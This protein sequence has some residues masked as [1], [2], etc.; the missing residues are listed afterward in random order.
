MHLSGW[1]M[2]MEVC[3]IVTTCKMQPRHLLGLRPLDLS[4]KIDFNCN[5]LHLLD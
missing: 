5:F 3:F 4:F 1:L 2:V